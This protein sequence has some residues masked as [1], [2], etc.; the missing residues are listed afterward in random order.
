MY[1][2]PVCKKQFIANS[3]IQKYC[4]KECANVHKKL[5]AK[6]PVK[7]VYDEVT[8]SWIKETTA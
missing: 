8:K 6:P 1:V 5:T 7:K 3:G 4:S 2:C